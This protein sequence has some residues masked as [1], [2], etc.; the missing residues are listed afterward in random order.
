MSNIY[1]TAGG[2][3]VDMNKL[4]MQNE[5]AIAVGN[6]N[7]NARGDLLGKGGKIVKTVS[8]RT[9]EEKRVNNVVNNASL[10]KKVTAEEVKVLSENEPLPEAKKETA[11]TKKKK[12]REKELPDGSIEIVDEGND[13]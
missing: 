5:K 2:R 12:Q 1:K 9:R 8:Q 11:A 6:M 7:V 13:L 3:T 10:K 4:R